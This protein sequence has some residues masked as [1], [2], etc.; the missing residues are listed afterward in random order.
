MIGDRIFQ[1]AR[2]GLHVAMLEA[3]NE[4]LEH[5]RGNA[6]L[7]GPDDPHHGELRASG[8]VR[9]LEH[10]ILVVFNVPWAAE[11]HERFDFQHPHGGQPKYLE[12]S[13]KE[14]AHKFEALVAG[15]V[16]TAVEREKGLG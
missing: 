9:E 15:K 2:R 4:V 10:A 14:K 6:P 13:V 5:A 16:H 11:Q 7:G 12:N 3:A 1:A 8:H